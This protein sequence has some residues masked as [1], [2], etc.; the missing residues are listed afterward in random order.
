VFERKVMLFEI[1]ESNIQSEALE[2]V[3]VRHFYQTLRRFDGHRE[4]TCEHL[5]ISFN[6]CYRYIKKYGI[7]INKPQVIWPVS[8]RLKIA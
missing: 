2:F 3:L 5:K 1:I 4:N 8:E 7:I 6:T